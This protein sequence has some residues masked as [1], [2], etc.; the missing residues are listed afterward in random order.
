[1]DELSVEL[2]YSTSCHEHIDREKGIINRADDE[3]VAA[4]YQ[5]GG[6]HS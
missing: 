3:T 5:S 2:A 1:M 4:P 6:G